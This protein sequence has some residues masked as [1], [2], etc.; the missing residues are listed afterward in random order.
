MSVIYLYILFRFHASGNFGLG[1]INF[2]RQNIFLAKMSQSTRQSNKQV[3]A[4]AGNKKDPAISPNKFDPLKKTSGDSPCR[5]CNE[6]VFAPDGIQCDKCDCWVHSDEKCSELSKTE[7]KF[8]QRT[9][10]EAIKFVCFK[11]R[12]EYNDSILNPMDAV[13]RQGAKLDS[14]GEAIAALHQ[15]NKEIVEYMKK[16]SKTDDSIKVHVSEAISDLRDRDERKNNIILYNI[17][18]SDPKAN[19]AQAELEDIQNVKNVFQFVCPSMDNSFLNG[20]TVTRCGT[21]RVPSQDYPDPKPRP[22]KIVLRGPSEVGLLRKN[23]RKLKDNEGLRHVG[24]SED[25]SWKEREEER[26]LRKELY[27]RKNEDKEDVII[28]GGQV[29]LRSELPQKGA[30]NNIENA[31][32]ANENV[33]AS[34]DAEGGNDSRQ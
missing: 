30:R 10:S 32:V 15:Q 33:S 5:C 21:K 19:A 9:K 28:Y 12:L 29:I 6:I 11:C 13:S 26:K 23:A 7:F 4:A 34:A 27:K 14:F 22:I 17:Q 24:I 31:V 25:K 18:E 8:M 1:F 20:K 16:N 3:K 2:S